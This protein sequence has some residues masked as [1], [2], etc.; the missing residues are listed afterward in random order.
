[1]VACSDQG[2]HAEYLEGGYQAKGIRRGYR[3][4]LGRMFD[5]IQ[6][7]VSGTQHG[8]DFGPAFGVPVWNGL[9]DLYHPT[10]VLADSLQ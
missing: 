3:Q 7:R 9:T 5:G 8:G 10:Q 2:A 6:F 1:M 4:V